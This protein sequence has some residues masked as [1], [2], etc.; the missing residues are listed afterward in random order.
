MIW[1][2]LLCARVCPHG[3]GKRKKAPRVTFHDRSAFAVHVA[4]YRRIPQ[5]CQGVFPAKFLLLQI[6]AAIYK[7]T[8]G[9]R[10]LFYVFCKKSL[11][12]LQNA[13]FFLDRGA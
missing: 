5:V 4:N 7:R 9:G 13:S 6:F 2:Q 10:A 8:P 11:L 12:N 3:A 1:N